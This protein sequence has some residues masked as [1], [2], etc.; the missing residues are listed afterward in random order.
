M[1]INK[2]IYGGTTLIDLTGD[3]VTA[4]DVVSGTSFHLPD[5]TQGT[6]SLVIQHY[7]TGSAAPSASLGVVGDIYLQ[8]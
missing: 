7:Y 4:A 6:G 1:A 8:E 2:V 5:G 3:D